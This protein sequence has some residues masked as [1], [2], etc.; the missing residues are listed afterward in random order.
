MCRPESLVA[1]TCGLTVGQRG[2]NI[3]TTMEVIQWKIETKSY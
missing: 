1:D 2:N 3:L